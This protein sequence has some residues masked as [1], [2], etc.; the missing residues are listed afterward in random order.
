[1]AIDWGAGYSSEVKVYRVDAGTWEDA[2]E[3]PGV[4]GVRVERSASARMESGS[5]AIDVEPGAPFAEGY[6]RIAA[7]CDQGQGVERV[8]VATLLCSAVS[9]DV[10]RGAS[11]LSVEGRSVLAPADDTRLQAGEYA[12]A[13]CD[14]AA[15]AASLLRRACACPVS[16]DG[17]FTLDSNVVFDIGSTLLGAAWD[18]LGAGGF[19]MQIDGRGEVRVLPLPDEPSLVLDSAGARLVVPGV[20]W[21]MD[22]SGVPNRYTAVEGAAIA[23]AVND[24][25]N[26]PVSTVARGRYVDVVDKS[27]RRVNG[28][29]LAA[30]AARKLRGASVVG[31]TRTYTREFWPGVHPY[32]IVRGS[33]ESAGLGGD[34]RVESQGVDLS[35]GISVTEKASEGVV[36]WES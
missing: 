5:F 34:M 15:F 28:E 11:A 3:L 33:L 36:L 17:S 14:G 27:P 10:D 6:Y 26:S 31:R 25:P 12:P 30:Y 16:V 2:G 24:D 18:V 9:G 32:S 22:Y 23:T 20:G 13:G 29:T 7:L 4:S 19:C 35:H 21:D 8:D 1:M